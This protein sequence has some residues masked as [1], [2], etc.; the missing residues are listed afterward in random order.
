MDFSMIERIKYRIK[1]NP[2]THFIRVQM[3]LDGLDR[4]RYTVHLP[5]WRPGRYEMQHFAKRLQTWDAVGADG[6]VIPFRKVKKDAWELETMGNSRVVIRYRYYANLFDAG[7]SF[8]NEEMFYLNPVNALMYLP[9]YVD[10]PH[11]LDIRLSSACVIRSGVRSTG[12][13][14]FVAENYHE[15]A[16]SPILSSPLLKEKSLNI[17]GTTFHLVFFGLEPQWELLLPPF[18]KFIRNQ[19]GQFG[20]F[21]ADRYFFL[22]LVPQFNKYHGVEHLTSTVMAF[23]PAETFHTP[24]RLEQFFGLASHEL[25]HAWNIKTIRPAEM[26]PYR[27][28][29]ENYFDTGYVAE[30]VTTYM[31]DLNL[32]QSGAFSWE[33]FCR[34][35]EQNLEKHFQNDARFVRSVAGSSFELWLDGYENGIPNR[36]VSIYTEGALCSLMLD[37]EIRDNTQGE[38]GLEHVMRYLYEQFGKRGAGYTSTD[39]LDACVMMGGEG[40]RPIFEKH[41]FGIEDFRPLL[42]Y[43]FAKVGLTI[44]EAPHQNSAP[45]MLGL[46]TRK[47][48]ESTVISKVA[49]GSPA[50]AL[51]L[52]PGDEIMEVNGEKL[53]GLLSDRLD[54]AGGQGWELT[55]RDAYRIRKVYIMAGQEPF[56]NR[57]SLSKMENA[58]AAQKKLF[59]AWCHQVY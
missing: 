49:L 25:Y 36:T 58:G 19:I 1:P 47:S 21:P 30:G 14:S 12:P 7:N 31:G 27:Y 52:Q 50:Y 11:E 4:E 57:Y 35:Q 33:Q 24:E 41:I 54:I 55:I 22:C 29:E 8:V 45:R 56:L 43:Y 46:R 15:L 5:A 3:E 37:L 18:E 51:G 23:G 2:N 20:S 16:D 17:E 34:T 26:M 48:C 59:R 32:I 44:E 13:S 39:F 28:Q 42:D 9:D 10:V 53:E 40:V 38:L 6:K